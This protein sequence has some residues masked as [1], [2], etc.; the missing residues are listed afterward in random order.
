MN[1]SNTYSK[2]QKTSKKEKNDDLSRNQGHKIKYRR[3]VQNE[4]E[5]DQE[6]E[7]FKYDKLRAD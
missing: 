4:R 3:R 5:A 7:E 2:K 6:I 1:A